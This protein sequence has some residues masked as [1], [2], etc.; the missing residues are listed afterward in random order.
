MKVLRFVSILF[1]KTILHGF[2]VLL[3]ICGFLASAV[4]QTKTPVVLFPGWH[5]T[6]IQATVQNQTVA[7]EC[8]ASGTFEMEGP[9]VD[10]SQVCRDKLMTLVYNR[11]PFLPMSQRFS[12][13][14][15]VIV[16]IKDYGKTE[17]SPYPYYEA[18]YAFLE[19][20]GYTRNVN[21]RVG[22]YDS[23]LTPDMRDFVPRTMALIE[24][25]YTDNGDTPVHLVGH[26]NGPLY[27]QYLLTHT[28]QAWKNKFIH[29]FTSLAGNLPGQGLP[30]A[31]FL[32]VG[33]NVSDG[34]LPSDT[35]NAKSSVLMYQS[36]PS[37]YMSASDPAV[38]KNAEVVLQAGSTSYTPQHYRKLFRDAGLALAEEIGPYYIGFVRFQQ[39]QFFP[40]VDVYAEKGSGLDTLVGLGLPDLTVGQLL[41]DSTQFFF[42]PGDNNQEDITNDSIQVWEKMRCFRFELTDNPGVGHLDL[43]SDP[44]VLGRLLTNLQRARSVCPENHPE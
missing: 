13:Q 8:P 15:G 22:G 31:F 19:A 20:N 29:G 34:S 3:C 6:K 25:T 38:F 42:L 28:S 17:S 1:K 4:A 26:S 32:F 16:T 43:P 5:G 35:E 12:D 21:I 33:Y 7:P 24:Q 37:T 30:Y 39:P 36:H 10:F 9:S 27:A 2:W 23:R 11:Q 14:P 40:N 44:G 18:L 41:N